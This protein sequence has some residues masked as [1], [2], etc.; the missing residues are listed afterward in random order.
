MKELDAEELRGTLSCW[1][2]ARL[3]DATLAG[4]DPKFNPPCLL[5]SV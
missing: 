2:D 3:A 4:G 5:A 1:L